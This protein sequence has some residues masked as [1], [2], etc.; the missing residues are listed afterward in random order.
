M[1]DTSIEEWF[2]AFFTGMLIMLGLFALVIHFNPIVSQSD[3]N[4]LANAT[5]QL[6][7]PTMTYE[8]S[9][10]E[11]ECQIVTASSTIISYKMER[12]NYTTGYYN[13]SFVCQDKKIISYDCNK[14][15]WYHFIDGNLTLME[16]E[17]QIVCKFYIKIL[18]EQ[19]FTPKEFLR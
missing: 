10:G 16:N 12:H 7:C 9:T 18:H 5:A 3:Y 15:V 6:K 14:G 4:A 17:T 13:G 11:P 1:S 19:V 8:I 2:G